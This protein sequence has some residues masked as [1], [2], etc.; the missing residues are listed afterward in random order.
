[1][2]ASRAEVRFLQALTDRALGR[3]DRTDE[4]LRAIRPMLNGQPQME[5]Q[6]ALLLL[7]QDLAAPSE[8][9]LR[10]VAGRLP[11]SYPAHFHLAVAQE[12]LGKLPEAVRTA[13]AALAIEETSEAHL[14]LADL[15]ESQGQPL[16]AVKHFQRAVALDPTAEHYFALGYEF[17]SH[18]NWEA[19]AQVFSEGLERAPDSW[20]LWIRRGSGG[21]RSDAVRGGDAGLPERR[22]AEAR[23]NDGLPSP[24]PSL[25]SIGK[26]FRGRLGLF[27][28]TSRTRSEG[29]AGPILRGARHVPPGVALGRF[30]P[31]RETG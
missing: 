6:A 9:L 4:V 2:A 13:R 7:N 15:L 20:N 14:L 5:F 26:D 19:A 29:F 3:A 31:S 12:R 10:S 27:P 24:F 30:Q 16:E 1:M 8:E 22:Q 23:G 17:L 18:W 25:R 28:A 21:A 11:A